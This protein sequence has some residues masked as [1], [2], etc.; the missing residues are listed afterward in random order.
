MRNVEL[1]KQT[2]KL[3]YLKNREFIL[4]QAKKYRQLNKEAVSNCKKLWYAQNKESSAIN[5]SKYYLKN[6][7]VIKK[8]YKEWREN[9][10]EQQKVY[11][12]KY[13][14]ENKEKIRETRLN[15]SKNNI[16]YRL[17]HNLRTRLAMFLKAQNTMKINKTMVYVGCTKE[18]LKKHI[19]NQFVDG[20][21][22][23][24]YGRTT[25][26]IDHII[27]LSIFDLTV[28]ENIHKVM[29]YTNLQPLWASDNIRKG[30]KILHTIK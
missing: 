11:K 4:V 27:P 19:E 16:N 6:K 28:E 30:N 5:K 17:A 20:M 25:W 8:Y 9:N 21:S 14:L 3:Y 24:N 15:K 12:Q 29:H 23:D 10:I 26:H 13:Y 2:D 7:D 18:E 1:K 22:W